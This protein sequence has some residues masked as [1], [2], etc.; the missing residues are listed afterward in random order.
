[1][2]T[3]ECLKSYTKYRDLAKYYKREAEIAGAASPLDQAAYEHCI[4]MESD[5]RQA[6]NRL[7]DPTEQLLLRLRYIDG[8]SWTQVCF[9]IHYSRSQTKRI[10][11][12]ALE[13]LERDPEWY[14]VIR[15][16]CAEE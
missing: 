3:K 6:I 7:I 14:W 8:R 4:R 12:S 10:H 15:H 5:I 2:T 1:M 13:S 11:T 9:I 16:A